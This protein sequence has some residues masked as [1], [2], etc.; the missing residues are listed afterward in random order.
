MIIPYIV[1]RTSKCLNIPCPP[2]AIKIARPHTSGGNI[3]GRSI[4]VSRILLPLNFLV[5]RKY[6]VGIPK[7]SEI[8][9]TT[10]EV[11]KLIM[12]D[13]TISGDLI[14]SINPVR[15]VAVKRHAIMD[16]INPMNIA[17]IKNNNI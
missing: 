5:A 1:N 10:N 15:D 8:R 12:I 16:S 7:K 17:V 11:L 9:T 4:N 14:S 13:D 6:A 3:I 2:N